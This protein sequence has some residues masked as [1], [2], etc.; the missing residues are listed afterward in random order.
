[1][2]WS[3]S[4]FLDRLEAAKS[5]AQEKDVPSLPLDLAG[6]QCNI[7][8]SGTIHFNYRL[9]RGDVRILVNRRR[10]TGKI[11]TMRIE[12]GSVSCWS[13]GY[14]EIYSQVRNII[15]L[16]GGVI[17]KERV[18]EVHLCADTIGQSIHSLPV[19]DQDYWVSRAHTFSTHF[20]RRVLSGITIG[21]GD[22]SLRVYDKVLELQQISPHKQEV[23]LQV[24]GLDTLEGAAVTRT[25]FHI[26]R[27]ILREFQPGID[28]FDDLENCLSSLW[29]YCCREWARLAHVPVDRQGR[30]QD[31][32]PLHSFWR[33][34]LAEASF[35]GAVA[36][37]R[38]KMPVLID[39]A[40]LARQGLGF[41]LTI[42]ASMGYTDDP[43]MIRESIVEAIEETYSDFVESDDFYEVMKRKFNTVV[44]AFAR[45]EGVPHG[46]PA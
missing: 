3:A 40:R 23:F 6:F 14:R 5:A 42:A 19:A 13:P 44:Q 29:Q 21:K 27:P 26:R 17:I 22:L 32:A 35:S 18:S 20:S 33:R 25:E 2:D 41:F 8:R 34:L 24:W 28:T 38:R 36:V 16:Y 37:V 10:A 45:Q 30:N 31:K 12:V 7:M 1:V 15:E 46:I 39:V 43:F 9:S 4:N 11:P